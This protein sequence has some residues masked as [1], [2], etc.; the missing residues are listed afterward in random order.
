MFTQKGIDDV[1]QHFL[2]KAGIIAV[3]RMK[4]SDMEKLGRATKAKIITSLD[5]LECERPRLRR[6]LSRRGR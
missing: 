4:K 2:A 6:A 5:D 1:A 3:R